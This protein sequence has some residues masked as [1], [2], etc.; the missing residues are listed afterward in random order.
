MTQRSKSGFLVWAH[1]LSCAV[2]REGHCKQTAGVWGE[3]LQQ[4]DH[5]G[6]VTAQDTVHFPGLIHSGSGSGVLHKGIDLVGPIFVHFPG[7]SRSGD[8]VLSEHSRP[9]LEAESYLFPR[10]SAQFS[11]YTTGV[12]SQVCHVSLLGS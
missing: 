8:Q 4:M 6:V 3:Y 2:G 1:F 9:Q 7:P 12:P 10:L 11:G 5:T